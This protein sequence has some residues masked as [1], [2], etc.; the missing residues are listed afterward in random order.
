MQHAVLSGW[1][2][3][4]T[5]AGSMQSCPGG[6]RSLPQQTTCSPVRVATE[7]YPSRLQRSIAR[8]NYTY[9]PL[10]L[11][12]YYRNNRSGNPHQEKNQFYVLCTVHSF[13]NLVLTPPE[14]NLFL[15]STQISIQFCSK[16][17]FF[18]AL[19]SNFNQVQF[20]SKKFSNFQFFNS[21]SVQLQFSLKNFS[22]K[23]SSWK[24]NSLPFNP[25][26]GGS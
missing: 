20:F 18:C 8:G 7:V 3:K 24:G 1:L 25:N 17:N 23:F 5:P 9:H 14:L 15:F 21:V 16:F 13:Q 10:E 19:N 4:S 22:K 26:M 6:Y 2:Q 12:K 11:D